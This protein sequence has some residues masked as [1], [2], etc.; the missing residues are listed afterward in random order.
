L[1]VL[2]NVTRQAFYFDL[3][4][5]EFE[6]AAFQFDPC[7]LT[8]RFYPNAYL[9]GRS[10]RQPHQVGMQQL[11]FYGI[12]LKILD[13]DGRRLAPAVFPGQSEFEN[14]IMP[15]FRP[16]NRSY[17][18]SADRDSLGLLPLAVD[19]YGYHPFRA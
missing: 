12:D 17:L 2:R 11:A 5:L 16:Q 15:G 18:F 3:S 7:R 19:R 14:R 8:H 1:N 4:Q 6:N 10:H 9:R 13:Y